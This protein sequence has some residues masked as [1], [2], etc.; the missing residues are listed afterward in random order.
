MIARSRLTFAML[1]CLAGGLCL[2]TISHAM[3]SSVQITPAQPTD[4]DTITFSVAGGFPDACWHSQ[5]FHF[6]QTSPTEF[7]A[8]VFGVDTW[9]PG[10]VCLQII[11]NYGYLASFGP[12]NPGNYTIL[13]TEY[14]QSEREPW[15]DISTLIFNVQE[16]L[17]P[18][19]IS[20][21]PTSL[22]FGIVQLG[23]DS[24]R[25]LT[26]RNVGGELLTVTNTT[27]P[28][29]FATLF[30][31]PLTIAAD[32]SLTDSVQFSP[33]ADQPYGGNLVILS[34]A[35]TSPT[36][37]PLSGV[38]GEPSFSDDA[39]PKTPE[40]I[41][42]DQSYP[43]PF[44]FSTTVSFSLP[45]NTPARL[46][47]HD[48]LGREVRVLADENFAPGEH[49]ILF[50]GSDLPSGIYFTR[51]QSGEFVAAQKLLLLK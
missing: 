5:D 33:T 25:T 8:D 17:P 42:L 27:T 39:F 9:Q 23:H 47:V 10:M 37:V 4:Q 50:D 12:L 20:L 16:S 24:V 38:A 1:A 40:D 22:D 13:I 18:A 41:F 46:A 21:I 43:N 3:I 2:N 44:N 30:E 26:I 49:R 48:V 7:A 29:G 11:V 36:L 19:E 15:P 28:I 32:S 45:R 14:P 51:L 34:N 31:L 35:S 6:T